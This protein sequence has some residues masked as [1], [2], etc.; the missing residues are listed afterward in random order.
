MQALL[1]VGL[2]TAASFLFTQDQVTTQGLYF[3]IYPCGQSN[4]DCYTLS[5]ILA[6]PS[7]DPNQRIVF[8]R[9]EISGRPYENPSLASFHLEEEG[10]EV[11]V[12]LEKGGKYT[13]KLEGLNKKREPV[14]TAEESFDIPTLEQI[15]DWNNNKRID[16]VEIIWAIDVWVRGERVPGGINTFTI[17]DDTML[18]LI[19]LW[20]TGV[21][22]TLQ[23][24]NSVKA[25][26]TN[27]GQNPASKLIPEL[28]C[29]PFVLDKN[30]NGL[31]DDEEIIR[32]ITLW[33]QDAPVPDCPLFMKISDTTIIILID[34]WIKQ[35]SYKQTW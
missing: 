24:K 5:A 3:M 12:L 30:K 34:A 10:Q 31:I 8:F 1:L 25:G 29:L 2:F 20:I 6:R 14:E 7:S 19:H 15:V 11:Q 17:A 22:Y 33:I 4:E 27:K 28:S 21:T 32:A 13:I 23:K 9:W 16:D 35:K 18:R 26:M